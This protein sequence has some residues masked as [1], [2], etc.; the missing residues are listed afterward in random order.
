M[1]TEETIKQYEMLK[2]EIDR[3]TK[4]ADALKPAILA[5]VPLGAKIESEYGTLSVS[6]RPKWEFS[7]TVRDME[8]RVKNL[9]KQ[10]MADGTAVE[11]D[12]EPFLVFKAAK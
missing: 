10:E 7:E 5:S 11:T 6:S 3:L 8:D 9:K 1:T 4:E 12:G 2:I